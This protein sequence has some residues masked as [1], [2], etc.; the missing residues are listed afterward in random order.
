M[1][2]T[3]LIAQFRSDSFDLELPYLSSDAN[4]TIW[5]NEAEN[6]A[7]I[8]ARLIHDETTSA[9]CSI[10]VTAGTRTYPLHASIIDIDRATFTATGTTYENVLYLTDRVEMD[11]LYSDWRTRTDVPRQAMQN[12]KTFVLGCLPS[13]DGTIALE[14]Y[15][16]PLLNIEDQT[17][18]TPEIGKIHHRHLVQWALHRAYSRPDADIFD[19]NKAATA[20]AEFTRVFGLR[21]D[22]DYRRACQANRPNCNKAVW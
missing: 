5:L 15:R 20:L 21:P 1:T 4:V 11:R 9:V 13:T 3:E 22:A 18:D 10:A 17:L 12:D 6:E 8:R 2:L 7:C 19:P 14:C 16:L